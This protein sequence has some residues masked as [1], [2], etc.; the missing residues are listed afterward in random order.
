MKQ[1]KLVECG[2]CV[3]IESGKHRGKIAFIVNPIDEKT[4]VIDGPST[5]VPRHV[6]H[7]N[8]L[9]LSKIV[10]PISHTSTS[11]QILKVLDETKAVEKWNSSNF[12]IKV[13]ARER[14]SKLNDFERFTLTQLKSKRSRMIRNELKRMANIKL[15]PK[16]QKKMEIISE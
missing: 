8:L 14:K 15:R 9:K 2:R 13:H 11:K 1:Q 5:L 10:I 16:K 7:L 3:Y 4:L 6:T 12:A